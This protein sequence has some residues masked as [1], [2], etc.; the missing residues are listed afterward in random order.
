MVMRKTQAWE[1]LNNPEYAGQLTTNGT[2]ELMLEAG[3]SEA[4]AQRAASQRGW[5]RLNAGQ[6]M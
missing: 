1:M 3:Y 6:V 4:E 2:Y 5:D